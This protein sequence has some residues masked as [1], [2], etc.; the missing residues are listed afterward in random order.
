MKREVF[1]HIN[2]EKRTVVSVIKVDDETGDYRKFTGKAK[3]APEDN[4]DLETGKKLSLARAWLKYDEAELK[5]IL[6]NREA[7]VE[8]LEI[9]DKEVEKRQAIRHRTI[10]KIEKLEESLKD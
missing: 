8:L 2:E 5:E 1:T 3:C 4:F 10:S 7:C 9:L 6:A